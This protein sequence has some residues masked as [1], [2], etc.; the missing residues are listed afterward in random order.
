LKAIA[1]RHHREAIVYGTPSLRQRFVGAAQSRGNTMLRWAFI[2]LAVGLIAGLLGFTSI[3]GA[4]IGIAK[5]L[6]FLFV[7]MFVVFLILGLTVYRSVTG[8]R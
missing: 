3:A 6:F 4:S 7:A 2:F 5:F 1:S 8:G